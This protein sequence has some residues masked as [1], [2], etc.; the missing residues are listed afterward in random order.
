MTSACGSPCVATILPAFT[1][2]LTPQPVPQKRHGAFDQVRSPPATSAAR[3]AFTARA[4][5]VMPAAE[6]AVAAAVCL[7]NAR[8]VSF[9]TNLLVERFDVFVML[10]NEHR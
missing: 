9:I 3:S 2:T 5:S 8:R 4:G 1:P 7:M 6:A 10:V